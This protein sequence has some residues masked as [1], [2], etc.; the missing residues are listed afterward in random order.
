MVVSSQ[1]LQRLDIYV[2]TCFVLNFTSIAVGYFRVCLVSKLDLI[3]LQYSQLK[4]D[5]SKSHH[6]LPFTSLQTCGCYS[7][8]ISVAS[9][10]SFCLIKLFLE[11]LKQ[12]RWNSHILHLL[13]QVLEFSRNIL[14]SLCIIF[15][16][17]I[18]LH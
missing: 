11:P 7:N 13:V 15:E 12:Y 3:S 2:W 6:H 17:Y 1:Q 10:H 5:R 14:L 4:R 8:W 18:R 16:F 9:L